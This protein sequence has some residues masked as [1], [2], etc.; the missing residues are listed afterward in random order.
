VSNARDDLPEPLIP[1]RTTNL[2]LGIS[3]SML[4]KL[5]SEAPL[6]LRYDFFAIVISPF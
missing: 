1:V 6:I 2:F 5:F 3:I 4:F